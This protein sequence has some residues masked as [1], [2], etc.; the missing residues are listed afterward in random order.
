MS[1]SRPIL[2]VDI[3]HIPISVELFLREVLH[4]NP[5]LDRIQVSDSDLN[6]MS[7]GQ[8]LTVLERVLKQGSRPVCKLALL[9][10]PHMSLDTHPPALRLS[11][12]TLVP[13]SAMKA[14]TE[15]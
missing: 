13:M 12:D 14:G 5:S 10:L 3:D 6:S 1:R 11:L 7:F 15:L 9:E 8:I 4:Q 2:V